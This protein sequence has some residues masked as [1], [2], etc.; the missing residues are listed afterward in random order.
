MGNKKS[1]QS[2]KLTKND[3]DFLV[4]TTGQKKSEIDELFKT[5]NNA[6]PNGRL[7]R[8]QFSYL[9]NLLR[10]EPKEQLDKISEYIFKAFDKDRNGFISF[11]E[12]MIA[13]SLTTEG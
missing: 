9:Y 11:N 6:Y 5:F 2:S 12:F 8:N 4:H 10:P 13:Y 3:Y 7:D 1:K